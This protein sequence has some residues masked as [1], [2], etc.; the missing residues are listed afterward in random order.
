ML[1]D[2]LVKMPTKS[3][4]NYW[5]GNGAACWWI[6]QQESWNEIIWSCSL[7]CMCQTLSIFSP[8]LAVLSISISPYQPH[9]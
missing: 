6:M 2:L 3:P 8:L 1:F 5:A 4:M 9:T 7:Y